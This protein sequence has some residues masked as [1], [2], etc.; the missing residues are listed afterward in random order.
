MTEI[1]DV[2]DEETETDDPI[3]GII[4]ENALYKQPASAAGVLVQDMYPTGTVVDNPAYGVESLSSRESYIPASNNIV[5][6]NYNYIPPRMEEVYYDEASRDYYETPQAI[7]RW[8]EVHPPDHYST[9]Q[10]NRFAPPPTSVYGVYTPQEYATT[11]IYDDVRVSG[12]GTPY[13]VYDG[14]LSYNSSQ[15]R[16]PVYMSSDESNPTVVHNAMSMEWDDYNEAQ[17]R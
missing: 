10:S 5:E 8:Y 7:E 14:A 4:V 12:R 3:T 11:D 9:S 17:R 16:R 13:E 15:S 2:A 6:D 1:V